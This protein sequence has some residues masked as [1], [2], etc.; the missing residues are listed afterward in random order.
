MQNRNCLGEIDCVRALN[1]TDTVFYDDIEVRDAWSN[2]YKTLL[3]P[4]TFPDTGIINPILDERRNL[5]LT[6]MAK[7]LGLANNFRPDDFTRIYFP[8][9]LDT[10]LTIRNMQQKVTLKNLSEQLAIDR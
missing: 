6:Q 5:L 1:L 2:L 3:D 10:E 4:R 8:I 9:G 7:S